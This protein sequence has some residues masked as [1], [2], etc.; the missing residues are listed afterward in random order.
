MDNFSRL[1]LLFALNKKFAINLTSNWWKYFSR[2]KNKNKKKTFLIF[3]YQYFD[4]VKNK[5]YLVKQKQ[6]WL[7][8]FEEVASDSS[9]YFLDINIIKFTFNQ[10]LENIWQIYIHKL[11]VLR[12]CD[13]MLLITREC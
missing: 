4:L 7:K 8:E 2:F 1:F 3:L 12:Q 11:I 10:I 5:S 13:T 6:K 9:N